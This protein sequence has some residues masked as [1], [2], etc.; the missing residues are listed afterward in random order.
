[1]ILTIILLPVICL[2]F[3]LLYISG[4]LLFSA[5]IAAVFTGYIRRDGNADLHFVSCRGQV[6]RV[7]RFPDEGT[8]EMNFHLEIRQGKMIMKLCDARKRKEIEERD[9]ALFFNFIMQPGNAVLNGGKNPVRKCSYCGRKMS[10]DTQFCSDKCA[11]LYRER[12]GKDQKAIKY[13][14]A[15]LGMGIILLLAGAFAGEDVVIGSGIILMGV[16]IMVFPLITPET[17]NLLGYR[18]A[19]IAGR[20]LG[21]LTLLAGVWVAM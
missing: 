21:M 10:S 4:W 1:M 12:T 13:F 9:I 2:V 17:V 20:I 14:L 6:R 16:V 15:G 7:I 11:E 19:R 8:Y 3:Y 18:K 5:K